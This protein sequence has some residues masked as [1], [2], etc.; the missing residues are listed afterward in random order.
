MQDGISKIIQRLGGKAEESIITEI[1]RYLERSKG[2][3]GK[4]KDSF[5]SKEGEAKILNS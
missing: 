5:Q 1:Y 2:N 4:T 3:S